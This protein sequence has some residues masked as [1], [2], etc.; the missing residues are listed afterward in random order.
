MGR[1]SDLLAGAPAA[2]A[3]A[4][5]QTTGRRGGFAAAPVSG[6]APPL[7]PG[8]QGHISRAAACPGQG[9]AATMHTR[10]EESLFQ[11]IACYH[12]YAA[13]EGNVETLSLEELKAL[14]M[15]NVPHFME[16]LVVQ[17]L[18]HK[19]FLGRCHSMQTSD[20]TPWFPCDS[21]R[22][23]DARARWAVPWGAPC[24]KEGALPSILKPLGQAYRCRAAPRGAGKTGLSRHQWCSGASGG[25]RPL[26]T[27]QQWP[28]SGPVVPRPHGPP[29]Q[30]CVE[31]A[32]A[33]VPSPPRSLM[34]PHVLS[35]S[36]P[37]T[38]GVGWGPCRVVEARPMAVGRVGGCP[39]SVDPRAPPQGRKEPYY[40]SELF[41]AADKNKDKQICFDEFLFVLGRL[42]TDYHLRYHRQLCACYCSQHS[43]H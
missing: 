31:P 34:L 10:T 8:P 17:A 19:Q 28:S 23:A 2:A 27:A 29:T 24:V 13:R 35:W 9:P 26:S 22:D 15:D 41:R 43:L 30:S 32:E 38:G 36:L 6:A 37:E 1:R 42:L 39:A 18:C 11:I 25:P 21:P 14:L 5:G 16:S 3:T 12:Q 7:S 4:L 20:P 33:P 40:L